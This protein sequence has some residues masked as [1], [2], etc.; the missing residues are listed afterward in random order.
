MRETLRGALLSVLFFALLIAG[1]PTV[2]GATGTSGGSSEGNTGLGIGLPNLPGIGS[3]CS[4]EL[5]GCAS[6]ADFCGTLKDG[7]DNGSLDTVTAGLILG[8]FL[9]ANKAAITAGGV[10]WALAR[11]ARGGCKIFGNWS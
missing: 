2:A 8:G 9:T 7:F 5:G 1:A 4:Y 10:L 3:E 11:L 6:E